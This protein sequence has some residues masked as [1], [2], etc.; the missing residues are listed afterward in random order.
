MNNIQQNLQKELG[1]DVW[2]VK[3]ENTIYYKDVNLFEKIVD[4]IKR[5]NLVVNLQMNLL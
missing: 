5:N 4:F 2:Y 3:S 1:E